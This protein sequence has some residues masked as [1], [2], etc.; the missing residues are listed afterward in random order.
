MLKPL[1]LPIALRNLLTSIRVYQVELEASLE[2]LNWQL[3]EEVFSSRPL[4][5]SLWWTL[6]LSRMPTRV[7][8]CITRACARERIKVF[9]QTH[10]ATTILI[11]HNRVS[12]G[13]LTATDQLLVT[14]TA[15]LKTHKDACT[16]L[17]VTDISCHSTTSTWLSC[18]ERPWKAS[19]SENDK[20]AARAQKHQSGN[21]GRKTR[22]NKR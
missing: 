7:S 16:S 1:N 9:S 18:N 22:Q 14:D 12:S 2:M 20:A 6:S 4:H 21:N 17:V 15:Q 11:R 19:P 13:S 8:T 3:L 10:T 5:L